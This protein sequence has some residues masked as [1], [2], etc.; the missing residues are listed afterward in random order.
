L[1]RRAT[2]LTMFLGDKTAVVTWNEQPVLK[3][4]QHAI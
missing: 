1:P 2:S 3:R 4:K